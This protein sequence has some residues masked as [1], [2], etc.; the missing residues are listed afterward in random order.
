MGDACSTS[1]SIEEGDREIEASLS[2][3]EPQEHGEQW[4]SGVVVAAAACLLRDPD[5]YSD[6]KTAA[7]FVTIILRRPITQKEKRKKKG[8]LL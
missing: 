1:G 8:N 5:S 3:T 7:S 2:P 4:S 6:G